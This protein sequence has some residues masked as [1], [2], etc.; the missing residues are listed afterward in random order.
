MN[1]T[2]GSFLKVF[3]CAETLIYKRLVKEDENLHC[4]TLFDL[5]FCINFIWGFAKKCTKNK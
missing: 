4:Y 2:N 3:L 1:F 5:L